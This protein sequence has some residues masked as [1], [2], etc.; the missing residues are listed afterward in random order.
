[1]DDITCLHSLLLTLGM[2]KSTGTTRM[3]RLLEQQPKILAESMCKSMV[4]VENEWQ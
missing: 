4:P 3:T 1:M 2:C